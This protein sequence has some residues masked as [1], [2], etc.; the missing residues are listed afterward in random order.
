MTVPVAL[1]EPKRIAMTVPVQS[2]SEDGMMRFFVP[3]LYNATTPPEPLDKRVQIKALPAAHHRSAAL[4]WNRVELCRQGSRAVE[5]TH[6]QQ[7]AAHR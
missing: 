2:G 5:G 7:M 1:E 3:A 6:G 4:L